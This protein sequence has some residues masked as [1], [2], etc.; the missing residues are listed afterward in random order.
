MMNRWLSVAV[1]LFWIATMTWLIQQKVL[2]PLLVGE[3]PSYRSI[4]QQ[5]PVNT[6]VRWN[7][8]LESR[9][10]GWATSEMIRDENEVSQIYSRLHFAELPVSQMLE[11]AL[12][13]W[14][15]AWDMGRLG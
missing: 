5:Q 12:K 9:R 8:L 6:P 7:I 11:S 15:G 1:V 3:A 4:L 10:I 14:E 13:V 2:P